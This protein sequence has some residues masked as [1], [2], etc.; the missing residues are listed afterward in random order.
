MP[1]A[2][3]ATFGRPLFGSSLDN[4]LRLLGRPQSGA[5]GEWVLVEMRVDAVV[6]GVGHVTSNL[7]NDRLELLAIGTQTCVVTES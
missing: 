7:W 4:T 1:F 2:L 5:V 6:D 3:S